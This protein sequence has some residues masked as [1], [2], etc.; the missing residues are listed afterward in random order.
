MSAFFACA[1]TIDAAVSA[2]ILKD[3][4]LSPKVATELGRAMWA[5]NAEAVRWRYDLDTGTEEECAEHAANLAEAAAYTW[6][7]RDLALAVTVKSLDCLHYQCC[8]GPARDTA[9]YRRLTALT[10]GFDAGGIREGEAYAR[11]PW[12]LTPS[13]YQAATA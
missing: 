5:L 6:A 12:G 8:E 2:S 4:P 9:L 3:E 7:P 10:N 1:A 11:A 13:E